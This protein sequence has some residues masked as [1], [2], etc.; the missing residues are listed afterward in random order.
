MLAAI[1]LYGTLL[2]LVSEWSGYKEV[3]CGD[4]IGP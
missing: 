4:Y 3:T 1:V 2:G